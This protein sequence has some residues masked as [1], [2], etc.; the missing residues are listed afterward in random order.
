MRLWLWYYCYYFHL[1]LLLLILLLH[2][3]F[4]LFSGL[5]ILQQQLGISVLQLK[6]QRQWNRAGESS[7]KW[8]SV[9]WIQS[10]PFPCLL[11]HMEHVEISWAVIIRQDQ[12]WSKIPWGK[13]PRRGRILLGATSRINGIR[14]EMGLNIKNSFPQARSAKLK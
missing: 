1:S 7:G 4:S 14:G 8:F 9:E 5:S 10:G 11:A 3:P 6:H 2:N 13:P 12:E